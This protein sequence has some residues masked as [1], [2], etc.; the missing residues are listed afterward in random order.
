MYNLASGSK[1]IFR[2]SNSALIAA[3]RLPKAAQ[4]NQNKLLEKTETDLFGHSAGVR[5][6]FGIK[7][8]GSAALGAAH[9]PGTSL[10]FSMQTLSPS[11]GVCAGKSE[12]N[13]KESKVGIFKH[14]HEMNF[15]SLE[16]S[17][18]KICSS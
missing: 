6:A 17:K 2:L 7:V 16:R 8:L 15:P 11:K 14:H 9:F 13:L 10:P 5:A 4:L 18:L 3:D 1:D 12:G